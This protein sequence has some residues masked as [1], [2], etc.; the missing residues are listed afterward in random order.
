MRLQRFEFH[1]R[2]NAADFN[3]LS[4]VVYNRSAVSG[5]FH[6]ASGHGV[7]PGNLNVGKPSVFRFQKN[8]EQIVAVAQFVRS[9]P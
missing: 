1:G 4:S 9:P 3:F 7:G 6:L 5:D 8:F 2:I